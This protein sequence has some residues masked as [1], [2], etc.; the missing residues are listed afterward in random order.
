M[1]RPTRAHCVPC[2]TGEE[3]GPHRDALLLGTA[4]ALEIVGRVDQPREG[5]RLA[6]EAIDSGAARR[7]LDDSRPFGARC[8]GY[9]RRFPRRHGGVEPRALRSRTGAAFRAR[10]AR[11]H[12]RPAGRAGTAARQLRPHR[13]S[14]TAFAR[15]GSAQAATEGDVGA[16]VGTYAAC[17]RRRRVD[18]HRAQPLRWFAGRI[19]RPVRCALAPLNVPAMRKDFLVDAYQVLEGRARGRQRRAR[20]HAHAAARR[21]SS[22]SSTPRSNCGCS[23]C[24]KPS[25]RPTSSSPTSWWTRAATHRDL[26]LV[27]V[28]SR[29]LATLKVVPGRLDALA[30]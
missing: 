9:E 17:G 4:L 15:G 30:A 5:V 28:N 3:H 18:S 20:H 6:K 27:G 26:L 24:S 25:I 12:R 2:S 19:S 10:T 13:R 22:S 21:T 8:A 23:C 16:R 14:K 1:P 11:A 29:D 7:T